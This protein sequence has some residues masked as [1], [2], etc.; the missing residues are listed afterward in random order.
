M[1]RPMDRQV[2]LVDIKG[3]IG[4]VSANQ[5]AKALQRAAAVGAQALV[6]VFPEAEGVGAIEYTR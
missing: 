1:D 5:L 2:L 4:V 6:T 3:A